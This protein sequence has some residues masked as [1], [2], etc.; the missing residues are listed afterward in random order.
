[1]DVFEPSRNIFDLP[2]FFGPDLLALA[3]T[4]IG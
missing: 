3:A 1:M 4:S 2:D